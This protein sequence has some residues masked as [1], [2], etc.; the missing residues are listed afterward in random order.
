MSAH[1]KKIDRRT[2]LRRA[3]ALGVGGAG[4]QLASSLS[5]PLDALAADVAL[6]M[7]VFSGGEQGTVAKEVVG[8]FLKSN[9]GVKIDFY[10]ESNAV[11]Y[12]KIRA[13]KQA[14]PDKPL[15]N[16]GYFNA[17]ATAMGDQDGMWLPLNPAKIPNMNDIYPAYRRPGDHGVGNSISPIG[18]AYNKEKV[19]TPPTSWADVWSN[20]EYKGRVILFDYLWPY[21][22]VIQA[23]KTAGGNEANLDPG[24][25]IWAKHTDQ[26]LAL[27]T[28]TQQ[29]Q[30]LIARGDAWV[31]IW[32]KGN[33]QQWA[34]AGV[35][36]EFVVP[37]EGV[38]AFPLF[39]QMVAGSTPEQN[40]I[41]EKIID[42]LL[43]PASLAR[44]CELN[45]VA[46]TSAK[47]QLPARMAA[48]PAYGKD[49]VA[50]ATQLDWPTLAKLDAQYREKWDRMVKARL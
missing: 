37:K 1:G 22:G 31:T 46:P 48:D 38:I 33:V 20:P 2:F 6:T 8:Q 50:N 3:T 30:N 7:F 32:A 41:A 24:M 35:P 40:A 18:I 26:I 21:T 10:E 14:N 15:V 45:G 16:F 23:A 29:A 11:A 9:P 39:F 13:A 4:M 44:W 17:N 34:D 49:A 27:V 5:F 42:I 19:K 43:S 36:V 47:V 12:P 28:S 25:E